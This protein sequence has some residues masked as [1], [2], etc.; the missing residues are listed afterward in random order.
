MK[1]TQNNSEH[2]KNLWNRLHVVVFSLKIR[3]VKH[4]G[5]FSGLLIWE[6]MK[7]WFAWFFPHKRW[8][9]R[10]LLQSRQSLQEPVV[11]TASVFSNWQ[12]Q[13]SIKNV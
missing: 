9:H 7:N 2:H 11:T 4:H 13:N 8:K 12:I 6:S 5:M 1:L 10:L 3:Q